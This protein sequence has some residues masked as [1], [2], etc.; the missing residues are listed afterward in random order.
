MEMHEEQNPVFRNI[1]KSLQ[2]VVLFQFRNLALKR[3]ST[4]V[5]EESAIDAYCNEV[6][7]REEKA[8]KDLAALEQKLLTGRD[9]RSREFAQFC[10]NSDYLHCNKSYP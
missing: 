2:I 6:F 4:S 3:L 5:E 10:N 7:Q 8:M 1:Q 9:E